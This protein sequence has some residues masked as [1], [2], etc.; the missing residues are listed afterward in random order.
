LSRLTDRGNF[1]LSVLFP[2]ITF[3]PPDRHPPDETI[4]LFA[5]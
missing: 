3:I 2:D 1:A 5:T 4:A